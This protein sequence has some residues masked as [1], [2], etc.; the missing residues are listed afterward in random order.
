MVRSAGAKARNAANATGRR[1]QRRQHQRRPRAVVFREH[2]PRHRRAPDEHQQPRVGHVVAERTRRPP[3]E[4]IEV[5]DQV[6]DD[7]PG[8]AE[9]ADR[10][11]HVHGEQRPR[12]A[13]QPVG[14]RDDDEQDELLRIDQARP[15]IDRK[16]G[17]HERRSRVGDERPEHPR[18]LDALVIADEDA[19]PEQRGDRQQDV[20]RGDRELQRGRERQQRE[21][22]GALERRRRQRR[23]GIEP[24]VVPRAGG[25]GPHRA[26][27]SARS[28][29]AITAPGI[30]CVR[31][32]KSPGA[33]VR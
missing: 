31:Q 2:H 18:H 16:E 30:S 21:A 6:L 22:R 11:D 4:V 15:R 13:K 20:R 26:P 27:V 32:R 12:P 29:A 7:A 23:H 24:A 33:H 8:G 10:H 25:L 9:R 19:H 1:H 14:Q 28:A 5:Q 17:R 3:P